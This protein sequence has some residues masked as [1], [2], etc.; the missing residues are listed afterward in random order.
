MYL[1]F[2]SRW[3]GDFGRLPAYVFTSEGSLLNAELVS[4][5]LASVYNEEPCH[6][7]QYFVTLEVNARSETRGMWTTPMTGIIIIRQI[8]NDGRGEYV[9]LWN[10][11]DQ[12][13]D[14]SGW[15]FTDE[16]RNQTN[17]P[18]DTS[19]PANERLY[20]PPCAKTRP[21]FRICLQ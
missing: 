18:L 5:S 17:I 16:Q 10:R 21:V 3:R 11:S 13:V 14:L 9:E 15:Y 7:H 12:T 2:E 6:F 19:I 20:I 8:F 1:A 4:H